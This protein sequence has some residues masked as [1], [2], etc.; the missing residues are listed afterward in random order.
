MSDV[1]GAYVD[2]KAKPAPGFE[3]DAEKQLASPM[4]GVAKKAAAVFAGAFVV[5]KAISFGKDAFA[6][7]EEAAKIGKQ[8]EA[9]LASTG[10]AAGVTAE[11]V[12]KLADSIA[13]KTGVDDEAIVS[14]QNLLLTFTGIK[15]G[16]GE[17]EK[18]FDR[19]T[20]AAVDM[21]AALGGDVASKAQLLGKALNDPAE[22]LSKLTRLGVTFTDAQQEQIKAM[23]AAGDT[24]AAQAL[25]LDELGKKFGGSAEA[26]A[27]GSAKAKVAI[28][29][30]QETIGAL[31]IPVVEKVSVLL[32]AAA[33]ILQDVIG[34]F[35]RH[36]AIAITL[37]A[38]LALIVTALVAYAAAVKLVGIYTKV[39][40]VATKLWA[41]AQ[42]LLNAAMSA[43]PI[44][45]VVIALAA[46]VAGVVLAY[47]HFEPFREVV[48]AVASALT[49]GLGAALSWV[50][51]TLLPGLADGLDAVVGF[52]T[53]LP[54]AIA[55]AVT[56]AAQWLYGL[57]EKILGGLVDGLVF[58]LKVLKA[59]YIDLPLK[60]LSYVA[61]AA[62]WLYDLGQKILGGLVDGMIFYLTI[63]KAFYVDLPLKI[64]SYIGNAAL[65]LVDKGKDIVAGLLNGI[66]DKM[67]DLINWALRLG[68][69]IVKWI[70]DIPGTMFE[71]G[72]DVVEAILNGIRSIGGRIKD[73][74]LSFIPDMSTI[75]SFIK[76]QVDS[77]TQGGGGLLNFQMAAPRV[78]P[79]GTI[80]GSGVVLATVPTAGTIATVARA[81][82]TSSAAPAVQHIDA[83]TYFQAPIYGVDDLNRALDERDR[84]LA[85]RL[86]MP[87]WR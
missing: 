31:L 87:V 39:V 43:N 1:G 37:G 49:D 70:G 42:W 44:A 8:T 86:A 65:W 11:Q 5:G 55:D 61:D 29:N 14:A 6:A 47:K 30:L 36:Q 57:G 72:T 21:A 40:T 77:I 73:L 75:E 50:T 28:G 52:F 80:E 9:V 33:V 34:W 85:L 18:I 23:S 46:L 7:A 83:R 41:A 4:A 56:G 16:V 20:K 15:N 63:V 74:I 32:A 58:Y 79:A 24:A 78:I 81:A 38:A 66:T 82:T 2:I 17:Q 51:D 60:I 59:F 25:I 45:L 48:D 22:G 35:Q 27:T 12:N 62:T 69:D 26:Q 54:G 19:T 71:L 84:R 10:A 68:S 64:L 13:A 76:K 67:G 53:G 3:A